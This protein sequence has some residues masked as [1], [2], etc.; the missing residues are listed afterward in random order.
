M[1]Q[2]HGNYQ[3]RSIYIFK[4]YLYQFKFPLWCR[5]VAKHKQEYL[6]K[7]PKNVSEALEPP[8]K[9]NIYFKFNYINLNYLYGVYG[10][11]NTNKI[12]IFN[13]IP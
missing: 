12:K 13:K 10:S 5:W 7:C 3:R 6:I 1:S 2:K 4:M 8:K 9:V 11:L